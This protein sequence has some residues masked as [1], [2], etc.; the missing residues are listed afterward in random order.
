VQN[1]RLMVQDQAW[2]LLGSM[3]R[4]FVST[5]ALGSERA[6]STLGTR[7]AVLP[8][9][10]DYFA[11]YGI[12]VVAGQ[13]FGWEAVAEGQGVIV[14]NERFARVLS[15]DDG[16]GALV[17]QQLFAFGRRWTVVGIASASGGEDRKSTRLN[18]SHVKI[19]YA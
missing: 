10:G 15:G 16:L 11:A 1:I 3:P 19:S 7:L 5:A 2:V 6:T 14:L 18:S 13:P 8:V 12:P 4:T 9:G 17:G